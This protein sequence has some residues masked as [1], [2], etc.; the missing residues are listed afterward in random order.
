METYCAEKYDIC[1]TNPQIVEFFKSL[2]FWTKEIVP[3]AFYAK[4]AQYVMQDPNVI[5]PEL[6]FDNTTPLDRKVFVAKIIAYITYGVIHRDTPFTLYVTWSRASMEKME[7]AVEIMVIPNL[8]DWRFLDVKM[9][10]L[11][12][13]LEKSE[14]NVLS[15]R[16]DLGGIWIKK[17]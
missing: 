9:Q 7:G 5:V 6:P 14:L 13:M 16:L 3:Y 11:G 15:E 12:E 10:V 4:V 8:V 1:S 17:G 2:D